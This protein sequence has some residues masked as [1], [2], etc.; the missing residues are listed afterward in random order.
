PSNNANSATISLGGTGQTTQQ[1]LNSYYD[2]RITKEEI[3]SAD[4]TP[5]TELGP[6]TAT[7]D[8][9]DDT[10]QNVVEDLCDSAGM[11]AGTYDATALASITKPVRAFVL[12]QVATSRSAIEQLMAAYFFEAY[13][14][15]KLYFVPRAGSVLDTIDADDMGAGLEAPQDETLPTQVGSDMEIPAQVA[16][17]YSN[18]DADYTTATEHSDRLLSG[19]ISTSAVQLPMGFT[20]AE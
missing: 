4:F 18:V 14:T 5:P 9:N 7:F 3:Y 16:L 8:L 1:T 6:F 17:S 19:Q 20:S 13:V 11:P 10:L 2:V 15:D 12:S